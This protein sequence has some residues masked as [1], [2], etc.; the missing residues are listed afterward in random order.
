M[1]QIDDESRMGFDGL[2]T[3]AS[4]ISADP[5]IVRNP[6]ANKSK[7]S[8]E[9]STSHQSAPK[10][11][12]FW[13]G[14]RKTW[15]LLIAG[16]CMVGYFNSGPQHSTYLP[17]PA[18]TPISPANPSPAPTPNT[19]PMTAPPIGDNRILSVGEIKY[20]L[21]ERVRLETMKAIIDGTRD[22]EIRNFNLRIDDFNS[23][24]GN[25]RYRQ[26][27]MATATAEVEAIRSTLRSQTNAQVNAWR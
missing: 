5:V 13:T 21:A 22:I 15:A 6:A 2:S 11:P 1:R 4:T 10:G 23:R 9:P 8:S 18:S 17:R 24:C 25:Y 20:C 27:D 16:V 14:S 3:L 19:V 12:G 26:S 7:V